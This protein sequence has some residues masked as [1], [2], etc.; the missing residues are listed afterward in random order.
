M[1]VIG[2][3]QGGLLTKL[4]AIHSGTRFWDNISKVPLDEL[5]VEPET[6]KLIRR[7]LFF[8]PRPFV[9]RVIFISTPH[10]GSYQAALRLA[11]LAS[12]FVTL[13]AS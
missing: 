10:R 12:W 4:T 6:Q 8:E 9:Q 7:S 3:S 5:T 1:V 11:R 2:H 13:P